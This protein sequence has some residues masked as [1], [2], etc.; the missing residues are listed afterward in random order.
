MDEIEGLSA[1]S[2]RKELAKMAQELGIDTTDYKKF[3]TKASVAAAVIEA[4]K[5]EASAEAIEDAE[6]ITTEEELLATEKAHEVLGVGG[7]ELQKEEPIKEVA[8]VK[9]GIT[10]IKGKNGVFAKIAGIEAQKKE[11]EEAVAKIGVGIRNQKKENEEAVAKIGKGTVKVKSGIDAQ[12]KKQAEGVVRL[13]SSIRSLQN[14]ITTF[15]KDF[16]YG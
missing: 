7:Q 2:T 5:A 13:Q 3:P 14:N 12:K 11:H 6:P 1:Q 10:P 15:A 4:K 9:T 16:Y 8:A